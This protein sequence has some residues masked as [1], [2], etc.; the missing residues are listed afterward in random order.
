MFMDSAAQQWKFT[1]LK[2][3]AET[4]SRTETDI[5]TYIWYMTQETVQNLMN[6]VEILREFHAESVNLLHK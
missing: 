2:N 4:E 5:C 6:S 1:G 3:H